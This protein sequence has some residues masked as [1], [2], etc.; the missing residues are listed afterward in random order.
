VDGPTTRL[1]LLVWCPRVN[2]GG[3]ARLL[4]PLV[5]GFGRDPRIA[6][7]RL[8]VP[9]AS[10]GPKDLGL[11]GHERL[12][13]HL[14]RMHGWRAFVAQH[15]RVA[16]IPG[17]G[18]L[19]ALARELL[20]P[21]FETWRQRE[22]AKAAHDCDLVYVFWPHLQPFPP[23][24]KPI[25]CTIQD[26]TILEFPDVAVEEAKREWLRIHDWLQRATR[27]VV[28]SNATSASLARLFGDNLQP[29]AVIHHAISPAV[30]GR[31][32]TVADVRTV[33]SAPRYLVYPA[34]I[35]AHKNQYNLLLTWSRF[36]RRRQI[37]LVL[38][39]PG[40]ECLH[41]GGPDWPRD[42][43]A[44]RL[45]GLIFRCGLERG[46]DYFNLGYVSDAM[47]ESIIAGAAG[48]I[49]PSMAEGGGSYP[50]EEALSVGVP[51]LCS[52]IPVMREHLSSRSAKVVWFDP[53]SPDSML[54]ALNRFLDDYESYKASAMQAMSDPRPTWDDVARAYAD[55]FFEVLNSEGRVGRGH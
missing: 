52:D 9:D 17:S 18:R 38:F 25:V 21:R 54:G 1:R 55:Q 10:L 29:L 26:T 47:A 49:M 35:T 40:T 7:I 27:V 45:A 39:G 12:E 19:K 2:L 33:V 11:P 13:L 37:P 22:L 34:N 23:V 28:S 6:L 3:G 8:A 30:P 16:G 42:L 46:Q 14:L 53:H 20:S 36:E 51:V 44:A 32:V 43:Q 5:A 24:A 48:L 15:G 4:L 31:R 50:V 41:Q